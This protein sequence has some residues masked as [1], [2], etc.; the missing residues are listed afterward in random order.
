MLIQVMALNSCECGAQPGPAGP[1]CAP[2]TLRSS[3]SEVTPARAGQRAS[4]EALKLSSRLGSGLAADGEGLGVGQSSGVKRVGVSQKCGPPAAKTRADG[5]EFQC[6]DSDD[7]DGDLNEKS[8]SGVAAITGSGVL[9]PGRRRRSAS[10][11][12]GSLDSV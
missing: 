4:L 7:R 2:F 8:E 11:R 1:R 12:L 10:G 9:G 6:E 5:P 3:C